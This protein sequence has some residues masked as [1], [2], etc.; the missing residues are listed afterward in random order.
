VIPVGG[1][2]LASMRMARKRPPGFIVVTEDRDLAR[3]AR[4]DGFHVLTFDPAE[5]YD[6]R[7][8]HGLDVGLVTRLERA[9]VS[10]TCLAILDVQ[11]QA[12]HAHYFTRLGPEHDRII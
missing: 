5:S 8:V 3:N 4:K 7:M 9:A 11:P 12:F 10:A 6:W 1:R 2:Q